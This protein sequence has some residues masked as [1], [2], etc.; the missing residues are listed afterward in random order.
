MKIGTLLRPLTRALLFSPTNFF[1][2]RFNFQ[3]PSCK[4][5]SRLHEQHNLL[6]SFFVLVLSL[7]FFSLEC[8]RRPHLRLT[9]RSPLALL[10]NQGKLII[11][12]SCR[13]DSTSMAME[14]Q[15]GVA[16]G[17]AE[18]KWVVST[19]ISHL[20]KGENFFK[21]FTVDPCL[22]R[23]LANGSISTDRSCYSFFHL[24]GAGCKMAAV[25]SR[26]SAVFVELHPRRNGK[27]A[28]DFPGAR[29]YHQE[30]DATCLKPLTW[31]VVLF[32]PGHCQV[33]GVVMHLQLWRMDP[34]LTRTN[35]MLKENNKK[36]PAF[37]QKRKPFLFAPP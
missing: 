12:E 5:V 2:R 21:S 7:I 6:F 31:V 16:R 29:E 26:S 22:G 1:R 27:Q 17:G 11:T 19:C 13:K 37:W 28:L 8:P 23:K 36:P 25:I 4:N 18:T 35:E 33:F 30:C 24:A 15:A 14:Y 10:M 3:V 20:K 9:L 34:K 32:W